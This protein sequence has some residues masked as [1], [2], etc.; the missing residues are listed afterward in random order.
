MSD[1]FEKTKQLIGADGYKRLSEACVLVVGVG[2]VGGAA[3]EVLARTG[4]GRL[5][6]VDGDVFEHSNLNRQIMSSQSA[7]GAF[8]AEAAKERILSVN[9]SADVVAINVYFD[10]KS[11]DDI[12]NDGM[13]YDYC[14]DAIDDADNKV[15]LIIECKRRGVP[16]ISA[17]GAGNRLDCNFAVT[18]IYKT[19]YDP[20]AKLMRR[21]LKDA[22]IASLE[23]VCA[24]TPPTVKLAKPSSIAAPP[25]VMGAIMADRAI[26]AMIGLS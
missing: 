23:T 5:V 24:A 20:F 19:Q 13:R 14:I 1:I 25:F 17:M 16:V 2:G 26:C 7:I 10:D 3:T 9:P 15:K 12:F 22:G 4:V 6:L 8:K 11:K 21:K 18:D